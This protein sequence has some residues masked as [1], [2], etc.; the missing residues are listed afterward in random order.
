MPRYL[1]SNAYL[2]LI[3]QAPNLK[4][5]AEEFERSITKQKIPV[6]F[7][8]HKPY[9][10]GFFISHLCKLKNG[11]GR[12]WLKYLN[13]ITEIESLLEGGTSVLWK[14]TKMSNM[15]N[16][17]DNDVSTGSVVQKVP[18][19]WRKSRRMSKEM[20]YSVETK[21]L[22][23]TMSLQE[24]RQMRHTI[25]FKRF[26]TLYPKLLLSEQQQNV[27]QA[28]FWNSS[29]EDPKDDLKEDL[30]EHLK[31]DLKE[32]LD[33]CLE[34]PSNQMLEKIRMKLLSEI[35]QEIM[36][37][38]RQ[39]EMCK[40]MTESYLRKTMQ[41]NNNTEKD[42]ETKDEQKMDE[43]KISG[44]KKRKMS[45]SSQI[46]FKLSDEEFM[47]DEASKDLLMLINEHHGYYYLMRTARS[48]FLE[49][50]VLFLKETSSLEIHSHLITNQMNIQ[51]EKIEK[52]E[53][54]HNGEEDVKDLKVMDLNVRLDLKED[55]GL[56]EAVKEAEEHV[57]PMVSEIMMAQMSNEQK[58]VDEQ[59]K[60]NDMTKTNS[61]E[62]NSG[63]KDGVDVALIQWL[64]R[65]KESYI[66]SGSPMEI[67]L[68][69]T[70]RKNIQNQIQNKM[71]QQQNIIDDD[72][73]DDDKMMNE[74]NNK[75][76][77]EKTIDFVVEMLKP[78][79]KE[80]LKML[81]RGET[82]LLGL[83]RKTPMYSVCLEIR[84][85]K[86]KQYDAQMF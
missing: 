38:Y 82:S 32:N 35:E 31:E 47:L 5:Q 15:A 55:I 65:L 49:E 27:D 26:P 22:N 63:E 85:K 61:G 50:N 29:R 19:E 54:I 59:R 46:L 60:V 25:M 41:W 45:T 9:M 21:Q 71:N 64:T 30:K 14:M 70:L 23:S 80:V 67:N 52:I 58:M 20:V 2:Q 8:L 78:A 69:S 81:T 33:L 44:A 39:T 83:F 28:S 73:I 13:M 84:T 75:I 62:K 51:K 42:I 86:Q 6:S 3:E 7:I 17:S 53:Q 24:R 56:N 72:K 57:I 48:V 16:N 18:K 10:S 34:P 36:P 4:E 43:K 76:E 74:N 1:E 66:D 77:D 68:S 11:D 12:K 40:N 37:H 79:R